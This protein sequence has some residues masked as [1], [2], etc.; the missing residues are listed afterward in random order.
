MALVV[1]P[2]GEFP[3]ADDWAYASSVRALLDHGTIELR[4]WTPAVTLSHVLWG[5]LASLTF[6]YSVETLR[7][8]TL[9]LGLIGVLA[10]W[11]LLRVVRVGPYLAAVGAATIAVNPLYFGLA[12]TFMTDVGFLA[13]STVALWAFARALRDGSRAFFV[14]GTVASVVATMNR[15]IGL[16]IGLGFLL[17][18]LVLG[19]SRRMRSVV[20]LT[21][22]I[23]ALG[24]WQAFALDR[25]GPSIFDNVKTAE[26]AAFLSGGAPLVVGRVVWNLVGMATY[27]GLF[28][29]PVAVVTTVVLERNEGRVRRV[30]RWAAVLLIAAM[31]TSVLSRLGLLLPHIG[32]MWEVTGIGPATLRDAFILKL[33]H[34]PEM[35][36]AVRWS[37]TL[38]GVGGGILA[39]RLLFHASLRIFRGAEYDELRAPWVL[40]ASV[41][42][43][44]VGAVIFAPVFDRYW[45]PIL[46]V[47]IALMTL[48][49]G[50]RSEQLVGV[51]WVY[52]TACG[53]LVAGAVYSVVA[54][55]DYL[56]WNAARWSA[57]S[58]LVD[59][60]GVS[61]REID[62][63]YEWNAAH[64]YDPAYVVGPDR[65]WWWVHDDKWLLSFGPIA[66]RRI[67]WRVP[68][69]RWMTDE[70]GEI[71]VLERP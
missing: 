44:W 8:S 32:N 69:R 68:F 16:A 22:S 3:L 51:R 29:F 50:A 23:V 20:P 64:L 40:L 17:S 14:L 36:G 13:V 38:M 10:T 28:V 43:A 59:V 5:A 15:Q 57:A 18:S 60:H 25:G 11:A 39:A 26:A 67:V 31:T 30:C 45:L 53:L 42:G 58:W 55:H 41:A 47:L 48:D 12:G 37:I 70:D 9:A 34:L 66:G 61:P 4:P 21:V 71:L 65:S 35:S 56:A 27:L 6:G 33:R 7:W 2:A 62:G 49:V 19:R 54:V 46:P 24:L 63:G 52:V 1:H